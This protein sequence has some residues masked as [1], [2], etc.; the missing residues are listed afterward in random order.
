MNGG[1][2][3]INAVVKFHLL[4][5]VSFPPDLA[6]ISSKAVSPPVYT[7]IGDPYINAVVKLHLLEVVSFPPDLVQSLLP[8]TRMVETPA[9][10]LS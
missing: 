5:V 4:E 1:D 8:S 7:N 3:C 10:M 9:L 2:P 6:Q